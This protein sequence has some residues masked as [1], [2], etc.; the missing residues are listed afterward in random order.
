MKL[1]V[2]KIKYKDFIE[3]V[4]SHEVFEIKKKRERAVY[5]SPAKQVFFKTWVKNWT[6]SKITE[7][8]VDT[9]FYNQENSNSLIALL[10]DETGPRGYVQNAGES[11]AEKGKSD[12]CWNYFVDRTSENQRKEFMA[13]LLTNSI[14]S[15]GTYTDLAPCNII[16]YNKQINFID[17]E[18]FRSFN[19]IFNGKKEAY[20]KFELDAW[21]KPLETARRDVNKYIKE[22][23]KNCLKIELQFNMDTEE[24]FKQ[25]LSLLNN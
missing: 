4:N 23:F 11:A 14:S 19:L 5:Y 16:F 15:R 1:D 3:E 7:Y 2:K 6:Q 12:K 24:N 20:E 17:F 18:S 8:G 13:S 10:Y 25:A 9:G 22:Y 21:W